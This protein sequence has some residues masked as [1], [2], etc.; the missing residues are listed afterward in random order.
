MKIL[1][2]SNF[3]KPLWET[4]G[5]TRVNYEYSKKLVEMGHD[6]TV[7]T[8]DGYNSSFEFKSN[9]PI[10]IDGI[11]VYYFHNIFR[12]IVKKINLTTPYY[13]PFVLRK[14][15]KNYDV[16]HIHEHRTI[17]AVIVHYY[18]KKHGIPYVLQSHGSVLPFFQKQGLKKVFDYIFGDRILND[19]SKVIAL[20]KTEVEQIKKMGVDENK[21]A[22]VP[23]GIDLFEYDNLPK[24][25]EFRKQ[26]SIPDDEKIVLFLGRIDPIKGLDLLI[27]AFSNLT[28]EINDVRLVIVG[29]DNEYTLTLKRQ[30]YELNI[31]DKVLFTGPLYDAEKI[32]AY[33]DA[34]VYILPSLYE[35]F[36]NTVL[37]ACA[38]GTPVI[39]TDQCG[40]AD[41]VDSKVGDVVECDEK[42]L[43]AMIL[44]YLLD[45]EFRG[46]F[47]EEGK[48][49]VREYFGLDLI[50]KTLEQIYQEIKAVN[51]KMYQN[52]IYS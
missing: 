32:K 25:G 16:I 49:V 50:I 19:A 39:I 38:C 23:N 1:Q 8:T 2:V 22:I 18:A 45:D 6:V 28:S 51:L 15:I 14:E 42:Q 17:L 4:G 47:G 7:Y 33:V 9:R 40:I 12:N 27:A 21:I 20:T 52:I 5:V 46:K 36:P 35:T 31:K 48:K 10:C 29:P 30:I 34:D 43:R 24:K 41:I 13:L 44:K 37:E 11:K 3:F 26:Y